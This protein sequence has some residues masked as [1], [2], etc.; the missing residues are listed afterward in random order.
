MS[1]NNEKVENKK[2]FKPIELEIEDN[3]K[4]EVD[5]RY[6]IYNHLKNNAA[7]IVSDASDEF[8]AEN[9]KLIAKGGIIYHFR[10]MAAFLRDMDWLLKIVVY[11]IFQKVQPTQLSVFESVLEEV[12]KDSAIKKL[13]KQ[14]TT[15]AFETL[16]KTAI[17][18]LNKEPV[19][20][21]DFIELLKKYFES[22]KD[23]FFNFSFDE[24][25]LDAGKEKEEQPS[26]PEQNSEEKVMTK[27]E[28]YQLLADCFLEE[29]EKTHSLEQ[30]DKVYYELTKAKNRGEFKTLEEE[31][32]FL[33]ELQERYGI[34]DKS[35]K[36]S[37]YN[38]KYDLDSILGELDKEEGT[39]I[40]GKA[41][42]GNPTITIVPQQ[43]G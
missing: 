16:K 27:A 32:A 25:S 42:D 3:F 14:D 11:S 41:K 10:D 34:I 28:R 8:L 20:D 26:S 9:P 2:L 33:R 29:M 17:D 31:N 19:V 5:K 40:L 18:S 1:R 30:A 24:E 13:S 43:Y 21:S 35:S 37:Y 39:V 6:N 4:S 12:V 23:F 7:K 36:L 15:F 38:D 22:L